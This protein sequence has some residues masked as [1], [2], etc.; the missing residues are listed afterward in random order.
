METFAK[1]VIFF[2]YDSISWLESF[3]IVIYPLTSK[4]LTTDM[5]KVQLNKDLGINVSAKVQN[6]IK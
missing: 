6:G 2:T 3:K 4:F 1:K 5:V